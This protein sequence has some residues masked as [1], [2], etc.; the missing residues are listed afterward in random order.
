MLDFQGDSR[1]SFKHHM[2]MLS[3]QGAFQWLCS[4]AIHQ[5]PSFNPFLQNLRLPSFLLKKS[6]NFPAKNAAGV[7]FT[8]RLFFSQTQ[9]FHRFLGCVGDFLPPRF[10]QKHRGTPRSWINLRTKKTHRP[11]EGG[12]EAKA[13]SFKR[14]ILQSLWLFWPPQRFGLRV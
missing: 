12:G 11:R 3:C 7:C 8:N 2:D 9:L 13:I 1:C 6:R 4:N 10:S 5:G 14:P